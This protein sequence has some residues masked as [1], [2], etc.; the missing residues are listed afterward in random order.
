MEIRKTNDLRVLNR[1][2]LHTETLDGNSQREIDT[3][4]QHSDL[5]PLQEL[6][7]SDKTEGFLPPK[8][9]ALSRPVLKLH[10]Q[11]TTVLSIWR[12]IY[13]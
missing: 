11:C 12:V 8:A 6:V 13:Q 1:I 2:L 9:L 3:F 10:L 5:I 4:L 7:T